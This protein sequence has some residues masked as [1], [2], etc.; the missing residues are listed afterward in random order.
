VRR[1][2]VKPPGKADELACDRVNPEIGRIS[3]VQRELA[4]RVA[5][6]RFIE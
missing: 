4:C 2:A 5:G 6:L 1:W 3:G